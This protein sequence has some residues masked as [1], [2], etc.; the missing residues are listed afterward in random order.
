MRQQPRWAIKRARDTDDRC[1]VHRRTSSETAISRSGALR[2]A[3]QLRPSNRRIGNMKRDDETIPSTPRRQLP[4]EVAYDAIY[5][6]ISALP[7][8][9]VSGVNID[10][11]GA[12]TT[13]L[14]T[15][16][17]LRALRSE[18]VELPLF[19]SKRFDK[20]ELYALALNHANALHRGALSPK[21]GL[22][23]LGTTISGIRDRLLANARSLAEYGLIDGERLNEC[24]TANGYRPLATDVLTLVALYKEYWASI[25]HKTP[26]SFDALNEAGT[27]AV[28]LL[29]AVGIKDQAPLTVGEALQVKQKAFKL[30]LQAY[31]D[32]RR[33]VTYLRW[34]EDDAD[35]IT[36]SLYAGWRARPRSHEAEA[37]DAPLPNGA[38]PATAPN[39][40]P[41]A[42]Q[43]DNS[44]GLRID[45]PF[46]N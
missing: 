37:A 3:A 20:L 8:E 46:T 6:E 18:I 44:A 21:V 22:T 35:Q 10:L 14:G 40:A 11:V 38:V 32:A 36:P 15:L 13:V 45:S 16:P 25:E 30:L 9:D 24:K 12:V 27:L 5:P 41:P 31:D 39:G 23:E 4:T 26:V 19:D 17:E 33:A 28:E 7:D 34:H 2:H 1:G 29:A 43:I 42:I